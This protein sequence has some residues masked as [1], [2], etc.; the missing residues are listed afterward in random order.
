MDLQAQIREAREIRRMKWEEETKAE[1]AAQSEPAQVASNHPETVIDMSATEITNKKRR[2][3]SSTSSDDIEFMGEKKPMSAKRVKVDSDTGM[4][5][6]RMLPAPQIFSVS[7][8]MQ[9]LVLT[10]LPS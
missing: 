10:Y 8:I 6:E 4:K 1:L 5:P 7:E 3:M 2:L 9:N